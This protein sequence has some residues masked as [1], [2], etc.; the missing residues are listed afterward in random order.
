MEGHFDG[1]VWWWLE[2][3]WR[4]GLKCWV[5]AEQFESS[6]MSH[7]GGSLGAQEFYCLR[8]LQTGIGSRCVDGYGGTKLQLEVA[9]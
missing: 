4:A 8:W 1:P 5:E 6:R 2:L 9:G 7:R 3:G